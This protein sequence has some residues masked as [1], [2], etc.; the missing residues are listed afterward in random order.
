LQNINE[1]DIVYVK[2]MGRG[3][4]VW[5]DP[6]KPIAAVAF[7]GGYVTEVNTKYIVVLEVNDGEIPVQSDDC[8]SGFSV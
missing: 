3:R 1:G 2:R 4:V 8:T 7:L 6:L 5:L